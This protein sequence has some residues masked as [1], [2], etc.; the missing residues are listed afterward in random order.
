MARG[1]EGLPATGTNIPKGT[2]TVINDPLIAAQEQLSGRVLDPNEKPARNIKVRVEEIGAQ[3]GPFETA[4][5]TNNEGYFQ[6]PGK[7]G[8]T[9]ELTAEATLGGHKLVGVVQTTV[10]RANLV[11]RLHDDL[12][13]GGTFPPTPKPSDKVSDGVPPGGLPKTSADGAFAPGVSGGGV[14]P[15]TIGGSSAPIA[16]KPRAANC[17]RRTTPSSRRRAPSRR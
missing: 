9:Y 3:P 5:Y 1:L 16:P 14:P 15:A 13:A 4:V 7:P 6:S 8:K 12:A 2:G 10:P 11:I 17:R